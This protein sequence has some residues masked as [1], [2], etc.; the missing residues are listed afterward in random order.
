[1]TKELAFALIT[2]HTISKSR[3]GGVIGRFIARTGL[4]LVVA[5]MFGPS[6]ELAEAYAARLRED[7]NI[8]KEMRE[9]LADYVMRQ[10]TPDP[11]TGHKRR[12]MMLLFEGEDAIQ[13]VWDVAGT[14][15]PHEQSGETV[16]D[17]YGDFILNPEGQ[18]VY[19]EPAVL[20]GPNVSAVKKTLRLWADFSQQ[21]GGVISDGI[22]V[23][24]GE[25]TQKA[26]VIIKPDN[27]QFASARP[28]HIVDI[29]S[30][31][32]LRIV[33]SKVQRMSVEQAEEFYGPV[34]DV[35]REKLK[36]KVTK[37][38]VEALSEKLEMDLPEEVQ[39]Q[40]GDILGPLYGEN[41]FYEIIYFMT[42]CRGKDMN[43]DEKSAPGKVRSLVL[44]YEGV[45]AI[46][47]IRNILGPTDPS[48]AQPGSVR[49]EFGQN[50]MVNAAHASDSPEN[51]QREMRITKVEQD[52]VKRWVDQYYA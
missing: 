42:G 16:R 22:G 48:K 31:S 10:F 35:L 23:S 9:L 47:I 28:G 19:M 17:T 15:R 38:A 25:D 33:A 20:V 34:R 5:R 43:E 13:K 40:M 1:M 2:P 11:E 41:Q 32:G 12:V 26:L 51:A 3:T 18:V 27:F 7:T 37:M 30:R 39:S 49:R 52:Y 50:I 44:V 24:Q 6:Q 46:S 29:F 4:E 45:D 36:G 21:D 8:E 14:I